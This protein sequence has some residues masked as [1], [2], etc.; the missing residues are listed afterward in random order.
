MKAIEPLNTQYQSSD[1]ITN[2]EWLVFSFTE[3]LDT[4][5]FDIVS[6]TMTQTKD[7]AYFAGFDPSFYFYTESGDVKM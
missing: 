4:I 1:T 7:M 5:R 3:D 6:T 2:T